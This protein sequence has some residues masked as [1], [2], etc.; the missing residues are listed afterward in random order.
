MR[1]PITYL[2]CPSTLSPWAI[3]SPPLWTDS[4]GSFATISTLVVAMAKQNWD[5]FLPPPTENLIFRRLLQGFKHRLFK[6]PKPKDTPYLL[7]R[8]FYTFFK[9]LTISCQ[10]DKTVNVLWNFFPNFVSAPLNFPSVW[11][12]SPEWKNWVYFILKYLIICPTFGYIW[13]I[14]FQTTK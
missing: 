7:H 13:K 1:T 8:I 6:P 12:D 5:R 10:K 3:V 4:T 11:W 14:K 9:I 2:S